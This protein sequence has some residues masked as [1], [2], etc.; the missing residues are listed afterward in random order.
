MKRTIE[1]LLDYAEECL[2]DTGHKSN[3]CDYPEHIAH[4][5]RQCELAT[6]LAKAATMAAVIK[7]KPAPIDLSE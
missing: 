4:L 7:L 1:Q 2:T 5:Q 6:E 3:W